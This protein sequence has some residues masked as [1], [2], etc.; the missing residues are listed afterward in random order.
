MSNFISVLNDA[1]QKGLIKTPYTQDEL[2][3]QKYN[4][5]QNAQQ[6]LAQSA[7]E[8]LKKSKNTGFYYET[9]NEGDTSIKT[10]GSDD[11]S[12][13]DLSTPSESLFTRQ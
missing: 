9:N 1:I 6:N 10:I 8:A 11:L 13:P 12:T 7:D 4:D 5:Y 2:E 3:K